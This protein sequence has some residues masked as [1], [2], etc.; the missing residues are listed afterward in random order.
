MSYETFM[1]AK[2]FHI[3]SNKG[4]GFI[5]IGDRTRYLL[6]FWPEK[7]DAI[8]DRIRYLISQK[9]V[10][11]I[12]FIKFWEESGLIHIILYCF[13]ALY[14]IVSNKPGSLEGLK[15]F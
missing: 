8:Y 13:G 5:K 7:Y 1:G 3:T 2:S 4:D 14:C 12:A 9:L 15:H 6:L 10:L 11:H